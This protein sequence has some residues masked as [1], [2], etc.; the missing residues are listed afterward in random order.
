MGT[1]GRP[2][3]RPPLVF[4]RVVDAVKEQIAAGQLK[5]GDSLPSVEQ[6]AAVHS[7]GVSSVR[8]ALRV[9][10]AIGLVRIEHGRGS[11]VAEPLPAPPELRARF[12]LKEA[13]A[14]ID[15]AEARRIIEPELAALACERGSPA[16][17]AAIKKAA[18]Q[19]AAN[20]RSQRDWLR[21]DVT[22][23]EA[24][25]EA[26]H[27]QV[28]GYM[29]ASLAPLLLDSRRESMRNA[30]LSRRAAEFHVLIAGAIERRR[31]GLARAYMLTHLEDNAE[32]FS[33]LSRNGI[34]AR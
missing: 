26:A 2:R 14:L 34:G 30:A 1:R 20:L 23:H 5:P 32:S 15:L 28:L 24:V 8:E 21:A 4:E 10:G 13:S 18:R 25:C 31:T 7:V 27:N 22:F 29:F 16:E 3:R 33:R 12:T 9:L 6:L 19:M 11:F 17:V